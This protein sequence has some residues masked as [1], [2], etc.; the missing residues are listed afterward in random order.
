MTARHRRAADTLAK[1]PPEILFVCSAVTLSIGAAIAIRLFDRVEP[2][3]VAWFRL[4][5]G[6]IILL[7]FSR[8]FHRGWTKRRLAGAAAYGIAIALMT[9]FFFLAIDR[10]DLG[11]GVAIEFIGPITVAALRTRTTRNAVALGCAAIGVVTLGG[12]ELG[13]NMAG[14]IFILIASMFWAAYIVLGSRIALGG[15]GVG[16]IG[17]GNIGVG[18]GI[19]ALFITPIGA[20]WSGPV[21]TTP[22]LLLL[23]CITGALS[24]A[25]SPTIDQHVLRRIPVRRFSL[26]LALIPVTSIAVGLI[27]LDQQ[28]SLLD[29]LGIGFVLAGVA[30]QER[31]Q[32][33]VADEPAT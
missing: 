15:S 19:G 22:T 28:P 7:S 5:T 1:L 2:Q 8:G 3:T 9:V 33:T 32:I 14:V 6:S 27:A 11:K 23:C 20:P 26:L 21:W 10:I 17:V 31:D 18:L 4:M 29:L 16:T 12:V 13:D 30:I 25:L 24:S